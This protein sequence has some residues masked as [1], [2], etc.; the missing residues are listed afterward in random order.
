M[1]R[2]KPQTEPRK[3]QSPN[4]SSGAAGLEFDARRLVRQQTAASLKNGRTPL[5]VLD[6]AELVLTLADEFM[7][8][9]QQRQPPRPP[10]VCQPGCSWCCHQRVGVSTLEVLRIVADLRSRLSPDELQAVRERL[11]HHER[12][13]RAPGVDSWAAARLP[14]P[15]LV[16]QRCSIYAVRPLTCRG[17]N[18]RDARQCEA[19]V[20]LRAPVEIPQYAPQK[21]IATFALDGARAGQA[22]AGLSSELLELTAALQCALATEDPAAS[23]LAGEPLFAT[24]KLEDQR[25]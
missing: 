25:R 13:R 16:E 22:E 9:A 11:R 6:A 24:A 7:Q 23:W 8:T 10:L 19:A 14:C 3:P 2:H 4:A 17:F 20:T 12:S 5:S 18:S 15:L 21:L 1:S